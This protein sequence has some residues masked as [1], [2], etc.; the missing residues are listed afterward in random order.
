MASKRA[1][2]IAINNY[3]NEENNLPSCLEDAAR[4]RSLLSERYGFSDFKELYDGDA[5]VAN[6]EAGLAWLFENVAP[7]DRLVF[8]YSGHGFQQPSGENLEE[9]LVLGDLQFLF[10]NRLSELSGTAP[11]GV[12]TVIL[13]SCFSGGMQKVALGGRVELAR[14]KAW[15]PPPEAQQQQKSLIGRPLVPR[16]FGCKQI[17][18]DAGVKRLVLGRQATAASK[19]AGA[20]AGGE[21][22]TDQLAFNGLLLS[23]C[24]ENETAAASTSATD[25]LSAFSFS[26]QQALGAAGD[27]PSVAKVYEGVRAKLQEMGFRQT[28][29]LKVPAEPAG[30][31]ESSFLSLAPAAAAPAEAPGQ[32]AAAPA[33]A[34]GQPANGA[35]KSAQPTGAAAG[36]GAP[37]SPP[38]ARPATGGTSTSPTTATNGQ[39]QQRPAEAGPAGATAGRPATA[40]QPPAEAGPAGATAGRPATAQQPPAEAG[41]AGATAAR[42]ATAPATAA[43]G[44]PRQQAGTSQATGAAAASANTDTREQEEAPMGT[45]QSNDDKWIGLAASVT[46]S[47]VPEVIRAVRRKDFAP[48]VQPTNGPY[49]GGGDTAGAEEKWIAALARVAVPAA[50]SAIRDKEASFEQTPP[51]ASRPPTGG[52]EGEDR[53]PQQRPAQGATAARPATAQAT[54][55]GPPRQQAGTSQATG[56]A[57]ASANTDMRAQAGAPT[58]TMQL[59]DDKWIGLAASV[60][61]SLVPEVIRAVRR[62][63]F[64]PEVQPTNGPYTG[65]GDIAG[66]EE[67]WVAA[68]ARAAV[69]AAISAVPGMISAIRGKE[70][71]FEQTQPAASRLPTGGAEGEEKWGTPGT[72]LAASIAREVIRAV[73]RKDF[74]PEV[75]AGAGATADAEEKW[76]AA[77]ARAA[78]P[79][80]ISAVPGMISAIRG[81]EAA[82]EQTSLPASRLPADSAEGEEKWLPLAIGIATSVV[83]EVI[84]AVRRKDFAP[85]VEPGAG[86][87]ADAEEKWVAALARA[88]VPAAISAVPGMISAIRGKEAAFEQPPQPA[89]RPPMGGAEGDE[90]WLPLA[91]GVATSVVPEVIRAVRRKDFALGLGAGG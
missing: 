22:E 45:M 5:T 86:A 63:D 47:L 71:A 66:A 54:A 49:T 88:A 65:S 82:F 37:S 23:A 20:G 3:G 75:E 38:N 55:G 46:A 4:F 25:G 77:L 44:P 56:A 61:A 11:P 53:Q 62:K 28:P 42:P 10:D 9:C 29:L 16:P 59:S 89:S 33:E 1:L 32:P 43:G 8:F 84:R 79:A 35:A 78:V 40:Q 26:L 74:A 70:A 24:S 30:L 60:T 34:P 51:A 48:E 76:V 18:S 58:D 6:A 85:E 13:D 2:L 69:P 41:P 52:A 50:I 72:G 91:I 90:K 12:L 64:A 68:L 36:N 87:T 17:A 80:A 14:S 67:K 83:P 31:A 73:R 19:A 15:I 57:A 27:E 39:P 7:D 21:D 81:K